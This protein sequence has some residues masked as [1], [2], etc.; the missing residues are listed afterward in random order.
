MFDTSDELTNDWQPELDVP[1]EGN[2]EM[3]TAEV[4]RSKDWAELDMFQK[5]REQYLTGTRNNNY[6]SHAKQKYVF[7]P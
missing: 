4:S 5:H 1:Q 3:S 6:M 2:T 7:N